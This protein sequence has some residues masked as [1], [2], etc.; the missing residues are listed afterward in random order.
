MTYALSGSRPVPATP[1]QAY[2]LL[3]D[4]PRT[5]EWSIQTE[6]VT[7]E[8]DARGVGATFS[9]RNRTPQREWTTV[10]RVIEDVP[11]EAFAWAVGPGE[12]IWGYRME[13]HDEGTL[14]TLHTAFTERTAA[15]FVE[16]FGEDAAREEEIRRRAAEEGIP[17][18]LERI[19]GILAQEHGPSPED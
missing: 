1:M 2:A 10:S 14:L 18:T 7:W 15:Y 11:G 5:G 17:A 19:A 16:R 9:G 6:V 12:A 8:G 4:V 13:P 3:S